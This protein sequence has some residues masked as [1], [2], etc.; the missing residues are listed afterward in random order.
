MHPDWAGH[1]QTTLLQ[2]RV[3]A[4]RQRLLLDYFHG[5]YA[6]GYTHA[7]EAILTRRIIGFRRTLSFSPSALRI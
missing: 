3:S 6:K 2:T 1:G 4:P 7:F 5:T